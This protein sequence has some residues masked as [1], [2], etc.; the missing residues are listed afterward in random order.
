MVAIFSNVQDASLW[1]AHQKGGPREGLERQRNRSAKA[2]LANGIEME[3]HW[4]P[5]HSGI[6]G[7]KHSYRQMNVAWAFTVD[8]DIE[9]T[10]T[11]ACNMAR[12]ISK[13]RFAAKAHWEAI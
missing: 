11:S 6:P 7:H 2:L 13:G 1:W 12:E 9:G 4:V 8:K 3:I 10:Y 5:G